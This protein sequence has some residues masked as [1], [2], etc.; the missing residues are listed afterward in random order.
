MPSI[1]PRVGAPG[2]LAVGSVRSVERVSPERVLRRWSETLAA[3]A[4]TGLGFT[5]SLYEKERF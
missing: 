2:P 4:M 5:E 3:V 1:M